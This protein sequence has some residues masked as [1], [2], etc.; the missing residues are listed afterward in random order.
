MD[1]ETM[2][3]EEQIEVK[4]WEL[5]LVT[6]KN[7]VRREYRMLEL[8]YLSKVENLSPGSLKAYEALRDRLDALFV[9]YGPTEDAV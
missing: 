3:L 8:D 6:H 9:K 2:T 7:R 4:Q 1:D 5:D